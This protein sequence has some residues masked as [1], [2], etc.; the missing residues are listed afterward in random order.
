MLSSQIG[1]DVT[2]PEEKEKKDTV[3]DI[4]HLQSLLNKGI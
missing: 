4:S 1:Q 2:Q 3:S